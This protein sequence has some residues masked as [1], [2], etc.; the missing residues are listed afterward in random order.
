MSVPEHA[1]ALKVGQPVPAVVPAAGQ[2]QAP[3]AHMLEPRQLVVL[4]TTRHAGVLLS[5]PQAA[6]VETFRQ[7]E[8]A[9]MQE[10]LLSQLQAAFGSVPLQLSSLGQL[11]G[12]EAN[13]QPCPS[14]VQ[15]TR[16]PELSQMVPG[17][18]QPAGAARQTQRPVD[19]EQ[20]VTPTQ[21]AVELQAVHPFAPSTQLC[22]PPPAQRCAPSVQTFEQAGGPASVSAS[23]ASVA[24]SLCASVAASEPPSRGSWPPCPPWPLWPPCPP[25]PL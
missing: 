14:W 22:E 2:T 11:E 24:A 9:P 12:A 3:P 16:L 10:G 13:M 19:D 15:V 7:N 4:A 23:V 18:V 8:L 20:L 21:L 5:E 17:A 1:F 6:T 25:W